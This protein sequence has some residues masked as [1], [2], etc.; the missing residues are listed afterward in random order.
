[1]FIDFVEHLFDHRDFKHI[2]NLQIKILITLHQTFHH[3]K[4]FKTTFSA[5]FWTMYHLVSNFLPVDHSPS[6][7]LSFSLLSSSKSSYSTSEIS[8]KVENLI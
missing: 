7:L 3:V 5:V 6:S 8:E 1:M 2:S 4:A